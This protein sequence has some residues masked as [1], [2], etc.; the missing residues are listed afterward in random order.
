M[1]EG[2]TRGPKWPSISLKDAIEEVRQ[3]FNAETRNKMSREVL[4]SHL[5]YKALSG[6][7]L[8]KIGALRHY[9]LIEGSGDQQRVSDD[10]VNLLMKEPSS[11]EYQD[12][13]D[14]AFRR[15]ALFAEIISEY[16]TLPSKS[17]LEYFLVKKG[18][19]KNSAGKAAEVYLDSAS[20]VQEWTPAAGDE[21]AS[22]ANANQ[23]D[24][25]P[26]DVPRQSA[27]E[28][29]NAIPAAKVSAGY[30]E[31]ASGMLTKSTSFKL[32]VSGPLNE[33]AFDRLIKKLE[34]DR[35]IITSEDDFEW[36]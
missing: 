31:V 16:D 36:D 30:S 18:F 15:P 23:A 3:V 9:G 12:A 19:L 20:F 25:E 7:A 5:G 14:Q 27:T 4:A 35:E 24:I 33:K 22:A 11:R 21:D 34:I 17:N 26:G 8:S 1:S 10:A 6:T 29:I 28:R 2:K 13:L 32:F